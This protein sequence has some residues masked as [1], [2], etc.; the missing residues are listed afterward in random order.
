MRGLDA[1]VVG[2]LLSVSTPTGSSTSLFDRQ[3]LI[4]RPIQGCQSSVCFRHERI[5]PGRPLAGVRH[6]LLQ[7]ADLRADTGD[8][9]G[10][11]LE[12]RCRWRRL[13][14]L[15]AGLQSADR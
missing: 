9:S 7:G 14:R 10:N 8:R 15:N 5:A 6:R 11:R 13:G 1:D 2:V 3:K 4:N 12:R